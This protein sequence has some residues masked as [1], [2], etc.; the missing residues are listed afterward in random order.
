MLRHLRRVLVLTACGVLAAGMASANVPV[1]GLSNIKRCLPISPNTTIASAA[2]FVY[3]A[4][5]IGEGG[6]V[7]SSIVDVKFQTQGDTIVCWCSPRGSKPAV[8]TATANGSGVATFN[9]AAGGCI[10]YGLAAIP[11]TNDFAGE[12]FADGVRMKEFGTVS[13]DAVDGAGRRATDLPRWIPGGT[14]AAG[15]A[16]ATEHTTPLATAVYDW[17]TDLNCDNTVGASDAVL[18]TPFL[19]AGASCVGVSGP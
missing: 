6:P 9:I 16:D 19:S 13:P 11:G 7:A 4:T 12:V 15:L 17:C 18:V 8:F 10:Q 1:P 5:V 3:R 14:C 2:G